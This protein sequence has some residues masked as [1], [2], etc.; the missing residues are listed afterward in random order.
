MIEPEWPSEAEQIT[1]TT[2]TI[3]KRCELVLLC[4]ENGRLDLLPTIFEDNYW[5]MQKLIDDFC[6][7]S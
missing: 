3:C 5:S 7:K 6:I 1:E 2:K 4:I